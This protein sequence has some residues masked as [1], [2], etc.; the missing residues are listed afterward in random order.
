MKKHKP[1]YQLIINAAVKVFALYG[2][3]GAQIAKIAETANIAD[4]TIYLYFKNKEDLLIQVFENKMGSLIENIKQAI[5]EKSSVHDKL[6]TLISLHLKLLEEEP[7]LAIVSQLELRQSKKELREKNNLILRT[8]FEIIDSIV[9]EGVRIGEF[10]NTIKVETTRNF[11]FGAIDQAV[12]SWIMCGRN[13]SLQQE[14]DS[15]H[16]LLISGV[17][18]VNKS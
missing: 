14:A 15:L 6:Y 13:Y 8:Y 1:K 11:I 10:N 12:T 18:N 5:K 4:G 9:A 7:D 17:S 3:N 2:Y 16:Q